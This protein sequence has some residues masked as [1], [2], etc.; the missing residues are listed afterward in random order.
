MRAPWIHLAPGIEGAASAAL[1]PVDLLARA[2]GEHRLVVAAPPLG[3]L[4]LFVF[5]R[6]GALACARARLTH[7][8]SGST[9][10]RWWNLLCR[11][12]A[13]GVGVPDP[14]AVG[15]AGRGVFA[16]PSFLLVREPH[17]V[18]S[19]AEWAERAVP[20][21]A[22][23]RGRAAIAAALERLC[24]AGLWL[25]R[26]GARDLL[27]SADEAFGVEAVRNAGACG[28]AAA[29]PPG[30]VPNRLPSVIVL[31]FTEGSLRASIGPARR[32]DLRAQ[33]ERELGA[34]AGSPGAASAA[35]ALASRT[36]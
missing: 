34:A 23:A 11:A 21:Q 31:R 9:A 1:S 8:R 30:L 12:R 14:V 32:R 27:L 22:R 36:A 10:E 16:R 5:D 3:E 33:I 7:P 25:P 29:L 20:E 28:A 18:V 15:A 4:R 2:P 35:A 26:L 6:V 19:A 24:G 17:S 13:A